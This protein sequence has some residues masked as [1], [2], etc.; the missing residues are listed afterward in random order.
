MNQKETRISRC[1]STKAGE[2]IVSFKFQFGEL[3]MEEKEDL[4]LLWRDDVSL[5]LAIGRYQD[6]DQTSL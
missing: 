1:Y 2:F 6:P 5:Q 3:T 4:Q